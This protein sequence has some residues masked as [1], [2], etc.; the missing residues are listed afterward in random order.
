[1][2]GCESWTIRKIE[3]KKIDALELWCWRQLLF[4]WTDKITNANVLAQIQP[5]ISLEGEVNKQKLSY[6]GHIS[7]N[8]FDIGLVQAYA[9][10]ADK[11][12][13]ESESFYED[14]EKQ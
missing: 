11:D 2:Y 13:A 6:F 9:P 12:M 10:T 4:S 8:P 3:R 7:G 1:M 5:V 14:V